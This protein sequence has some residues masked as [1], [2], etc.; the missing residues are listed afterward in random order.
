VGAVFADFCAAIEDAGKPSASECEQRTWAERADGSERRIL[1][2]VRWDG[3][4]MD[5]VCASAFLIERLRNFSILSTVE[6]GFMPICDKS[7]VVVAKSGEEI[8]GRLML[9]SPAHVEG[10]WI[11]ER[12]RG[13]RLLKRMMDEMES[14][15]KH[16]GLAKLMAY[17]HSINEDYLERLGFVKRPLTVWEKRLV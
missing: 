4:K 5:Q 14:Q 13:G 16:E 11:D 17:G 3:S 1:V 8:I 2:R 9:L 12:F 7:I 6:E 10:A 15:A